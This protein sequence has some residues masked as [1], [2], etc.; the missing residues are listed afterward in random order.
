[1]LK[2]MAEIL[3][4]GADEIAVEDFEI[5]DDYSGR[6]MNGETTY[7]VVATCW[8]DVTAAAAM[9]AHY[10]VDREHFMS[11]ANFAAGMAD[12]RSDSMGTAIVIY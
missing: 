9:A 2:E 10:H 6:G 5:R 8:Q 3:K 12:L 4:M 1:M 11:G 7:A